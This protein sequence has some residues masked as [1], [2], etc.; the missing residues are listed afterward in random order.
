MTR[1]ATRGHVAE[2]VAEKLKVTCQMKKKD[3]KSLKKLK[4]E[5]EN[6]GGVPRGPQFGGGG[7]KNKVLFFSLFKVGSLSFYFP[8]S[9]FSD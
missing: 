5:R 4:Q 2:L 9:L 8:R 6:I 3:K 1:H 7:L